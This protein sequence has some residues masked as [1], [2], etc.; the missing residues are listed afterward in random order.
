[1]CKPASFVVTRNG[2]VF[3]SKYTDSHEA[4]IKEFELNEGSGAFTDNANFVR[5]EICPTEENKLNTPIKDWVYNLDQQ[6]PPDG[7]DAKECEKSCR[8]ELKKWHKQKII[9]KS[10]AELK[11]GQFYVY[12][13]ATIESVYGNATIEYVSGNATIES[14]YDNATIKSVYGNATIK[15]VSDNATIKSVSGNATMVKIEGSATAI[16]YK[17][18]D[19]KCLQSSTAVMIDRSGKGV[20]VFVGGVEFKK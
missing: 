16:V 10:C 1:M 19:P 5:V 18:V 20:K 6:D 12:G 7:Y 11:D 17:A 9:T 14:V 3:W 8:L 2:K 4:I 15:Y 13:N